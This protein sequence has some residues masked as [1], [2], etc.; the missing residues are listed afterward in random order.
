MT[1]IF[2]LDMVGVIE[3][4]DKSSSVGLAWDYL[5]HYERLLHDF[6][7]LPINLIEIGIAGGTSLAIWKSYFPSHRSLGLTTIPRA[8]ASPA[9]GSISRS[10]H[11]TIRGSS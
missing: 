4:T 10:D 2:N 9:I 5:R 7:D 3:G 6:R 1:G 11:R 8:G